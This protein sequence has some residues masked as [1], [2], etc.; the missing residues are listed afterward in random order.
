LNEIKLNKKI[1][2]KIDENKGMPKI[3]STETMKL[4]PVAH[5]LRNEDNCMVGS[6]DTGMQTEIYFNPM[7]IFVYVM[8]V[9]V[10]IYIYI[11]REREKLHDELLLYIDFS[12]D[13]CYSTHRVCSSRCV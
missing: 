1:E 2:I 3:R 8:C 9:C 5:R 12:R 6:W 7:C 10:C 13:V 11:A 4:N